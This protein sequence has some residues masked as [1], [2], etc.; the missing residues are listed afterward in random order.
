MDADNVYF[1]MEMAEKGS[2][3]DLLEDVYEDSQ[4]LPINTVRFFVA[5]IIIALENIF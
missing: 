4:G 5:E 3:Q 2:L 1:L